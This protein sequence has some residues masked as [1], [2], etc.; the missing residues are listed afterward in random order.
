[1]CARACVQCVCARACVQCVRACVQCVCL[2]AVCVHVCTRE[3]VRVS[4]VA[5]VHVC[6]CIHSSVPIASLSV[7]VCEHVCAHICM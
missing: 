4:V 7:S 2:R 3:L 6:S 1:M 5:R